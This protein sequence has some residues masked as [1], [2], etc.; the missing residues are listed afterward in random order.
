MI[1][2]VRHRSYTAFQDFRHD[3]AAYLEAVHSAHQALP[4]LTEAQQAWAEAL[5]WLRADYWQ[6][7]LFHPATELAGL[8]F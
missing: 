3:L 5:D 2:Q 8:T 1:D 4:N 7:Y 6:R